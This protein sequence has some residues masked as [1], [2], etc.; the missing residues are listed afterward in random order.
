[1]STKRRVTV[2]VL[3]AVLGMPLVGGC[4]NN[5]TCDAMTL[6]LTGADAGGKGG[7]KSKSKTGGKS[8]TK[9]GGGISNDDCDD[10]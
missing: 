4:D 2:I 10:D 9:T 3:A 5:S 7:G 1:M 6:S 8:K